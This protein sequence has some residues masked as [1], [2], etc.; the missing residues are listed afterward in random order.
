MKIPHEKEASNAY[1]KFLQTKGAAA[2][3]L[4][5][6][7]V[8]LDKLIAN[9][10]GR[11]LERTEYGQALDATMK[12]VSADDKHD[13]LNTAREFYPFWMNDIKAIAAFQLHYGFDIESI[14]WKPLPISLKSLTDNLD[15][16]KFSR[17]ENQALD[18]YS[19]ALYD[20]GAEKS[21]VDSR[22]KLSKVILIRLRDAPIE[23]NKS[24][25]MAVDITLPLFNINEIK[26][27][28]LVVVR[29]FYYFWTRDLDAPSK[30]SKGI[31]SNKI[32]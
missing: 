18:A 26:Q 19:G 24:Y 15:T 10:A 22:I 16:E 7:S 27:L 4:H 25:R 11:A 8:F 1:L 13:Y 21:L 31:S 30:I 28:F 29:E 2:G 14:Q 17:Q 5:K 23:N 12:T 32:Q 20:A 3:T 9:L 6:H